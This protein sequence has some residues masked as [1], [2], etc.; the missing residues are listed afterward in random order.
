MQR[1]AWLGLF[2]SLGCGMD[3]A[4]AAGPE[5]PTVGGKAD[6]PVAAS[7][8]EGD[9]GDPMFPV[10][11][12]QRLSRRY[13]T[14]IS[15]LTADEVARVEAAIM[16]TPGYEEATFDTVQQS[17]LDGTIIVDDLLVN[18]ERFTLA[19]WYEAQDALVG[20]VVSRNLEAFATMRGDEWTH[21]RTL[22]GPAATPSQECDDTI[23]RLVVVDYTPYAR[24]NAG[25][26]RDQIASIDT[27]LVE[28]DGNREVVLARA[29]HRDDPEY[30]A[31]FLVV[32]E[33]TYGGCRVAG[34]QAQLRPV[35]MTMTTYGPPPR[36]LLNN[37][38]AGGNLPQCWAD[39]RNMAALLGEPGAERPFLDPNYEVLSENNDE[40]LV[41]LR[42]VDRDEA[43]IARIS[44]PEDEANF[45]SIYGMMSA[46]NDHPLVFQ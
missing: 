45:C 17:A 18:A 24:L 6:G 37:I 39:L 5:S 20:A 19:Q 35:D 38:F 26:F 16:A 32:T 33:R 41:R 28:S 22:D 43:W 42:A 9:G 40:M 36:R 44:R 4:P 14:Q 12:H 34:I 15:E 27:L 21:L 23:R 13:V 31:D 29:V 3:P 11:R 2:L 8:V 25:Y 30:I 1:F 46:D 10:Y 7:Y